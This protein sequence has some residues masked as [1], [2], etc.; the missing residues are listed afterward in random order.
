MAISN[1]CVWEVRATGNN[2]NG[3]GFV[4]GSSGT[5]F[6]QQ[7]TAQFALTG[8]ASAGAGSVFLTS[9]AAASM[10]G[11]IC[12]V[13][14]GTNFTVGLYQITSVTVGV[15]VTV[16]RA[17]T[18][19]VGSGGVINIG[20]AFA[21]IQTGVSAMTVDTQLCYV[22][23]ATYAITSA[24]ATVAV[25]NV[26]FAASVI[27]YG[28]VRGDNGKVTVT[29]N[30]AINGLSIANSGWKFWNFIFQNLGGGL[31]GASISSTY[32]GLFNC[33]IINFPTGITA[34]STE[35]ILVRSSV[36]GA[37]T[38]AFN[39]TGAA[40]TV[41]CCTSIAN[42]CHGFTIAGVNISLTVCA[43]VN[44]TGGSSDGFNCTNFATKFFNCLAY[45]NGRDGVRFSLPYGLNIGTTVLNCILAKNVGYGLNMAVA[46]TLRNTPATQNNAFWSNGIAASNNYVSPASDVLIAGVDPANDPFVNK[47]GL[48]FALN[49]TGGAGAL[50]RAAGFIGTLP[51]LSTTGYE[52]IGPF[53][54]QDSGGTA[55]IIRNPEL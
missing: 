11:N 27:G 51:S 32:G 45:N 55:G 37:T 54:H 52:D 47:A 8:V 40:T 16:D 22:R 44:N 46:A 9:S 53:Q 50:L 34:S 25:S 19:G 49:A 13:V 43:S 23:A 12:R 21:S 17:I 7:D 3:G 38:A 14:S 35:C 10:V 30:S 4:T 39:L 33:E 1:L 42:T 28:T 41:T 18:T 5:D 6:S 31:T 20:G 24:I 15:S 26:E 2:D 48:N 29:V 36:T